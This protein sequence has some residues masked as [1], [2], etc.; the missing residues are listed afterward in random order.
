MH[1]FTYWICLWAHL[2]S[3]E[4]LLANP[5]FEQL[6]LQGRPSPWALYVM[7]LRGALGEVDD[8][9]HDG[10]LSVKLRIAEP[11]DEEPVNNWSQVVIR[12]LAGKTLQL[13]GQLR[14][15][16]ATEAAIW[17]QCFR[18]NPT[19]VVAAATT[20]VEWPVYGTRDWER[21]ELTLDAPD[22]TDFV[23]VRCVLL[24]TGSAWFDS[25][26]LTAEEEVMEPLDALEPALEDEEKGRI[27]RRMAREVVEV[28]GAL[29]ASIRELETSNATLVTRIG[30][31]Q[32]ELARYREEMAAARVPQLEADLESIRL[33]QIRHP[34]VPR[35]YSDSEAN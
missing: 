34:L 11:Y 21:I 8:V 9:A 6:D 10:S 15:D 13:S 26:E 2:V 32:R 4:N 17:L 28:S 29:K 24:G 33:N 23:V 30:E 18:R 1:A 12:D 3:A 20:S 7:P 27:S 16:E 22:D 35:G 19:R 5:G 14:V 31:I 25:L